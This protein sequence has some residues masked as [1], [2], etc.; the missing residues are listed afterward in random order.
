MADPQTIESVAR[1][2]V[3]PRRLPADRV[4]LDP[5][6]TLELALLGAVAQRTVTLDRVVDIVGCLAGDNWCLS[7]E[8]VYH[9]LQGATRSGLIAARETWVN[10]V[11]FV[12]ALTPAG[13]VRFAE[14]MRLRLPQADTPD[15]CAAAAV[16]YGL[17]DL[18]DR[19]ETGPVCADL[20]RFYLSCR[21]GLEACRVGLPPHRPYLDRAIRERQAWIDRRI[22]VL[23][24]SAGVPAAPAADRAA[25]PAT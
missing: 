15:A 6:A 7:R 18:V 17:L 13:A 24:A 23:E 8:V 16:K 21:S 1:I 5:G 10:S 12:Y 9:A 14:L 3:L 22:A 20:R 25:A 11:P 4:V 2:V 19:L